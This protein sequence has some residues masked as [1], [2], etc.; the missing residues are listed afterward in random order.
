MSINED[1]VIKYGMDHC[2]ARSVSFHYIRG[3]ELKRFHAI[4]YHLC[5]NIKK[6]ENER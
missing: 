4:L 3:D 2:A 1:N 5:P 6:E